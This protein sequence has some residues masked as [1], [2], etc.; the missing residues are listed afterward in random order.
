[1]RSVLFL[2][3]RSRLPE[4][5]PRMRIM[6]LE[7]V[8]VDAYHV[9]EIGFLLS[10]VVY[11]VVLFFQERFLVTILKTRLVSLASCLNLWS[12]VVYGF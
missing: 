9:L 4:R 8:L 5:L 12:L 1:M 11:G 6:S 7:K 3:S 10:A 2:L